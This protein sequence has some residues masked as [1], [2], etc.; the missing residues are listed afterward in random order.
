[1]TSNPVADI[2]DVF[3]PP[4]SIYTVEDGI[5]DCSM[6]EIDTALRA[7]A[8]Y[9]IRVV[10]TRAAWQAVIEWTRTD[11]PNDETGRAWD[12][13][14]TLRGAAKAASGGPGRRCRFSV[15]RVPNRTKS[16]RPSESM[17]ATRQQLEVVAQAFNL[18]EPCLTILLPGES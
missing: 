14:N 15:F 1:M 16:G 4:I 6:V 17:T 9:R 13:L 3:G 5:A 10:A 11:W 18:V 2:L 12:V 8:G 7:E